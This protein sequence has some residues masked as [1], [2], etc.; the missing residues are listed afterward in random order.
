MYL[1]SMCQMYIQH[2]PQ[3]FNPAQKP[4]SLVDDTPTR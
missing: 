1:L 2:A 3:S 4:S